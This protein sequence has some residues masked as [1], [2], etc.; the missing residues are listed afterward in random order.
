VL[1]Q[2]PQRQRTASEDQFW[3]GRRASHRLAVLGSSTNER[4]SK[5]LDKAHLESEG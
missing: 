5:T 4:T 2:W 3:T 1:K